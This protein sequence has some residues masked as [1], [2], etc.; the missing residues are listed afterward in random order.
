M[1]IALRPVQQLLLNKGIVRDDDGRLRIFSPAFADC[2]D[3][4]GD[5]GDRP[6]EILRHLYPKDK[7]IVGNAVEA[8]VKR[9]RQKIE[10]ERHRPRYLLTVHGKGYRLVS[11]PSPDKSQAQGAR[12]T[13]S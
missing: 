5:P 2:V 10:P 8:L 13:R 7:V 9:L 1:D 3:R 6:L 4:E 11:H 12:T